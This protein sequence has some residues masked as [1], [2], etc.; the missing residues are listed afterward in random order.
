MKKK[1]TEEQ[2]TILNYKLYQHQQT[3]HLLVLIKCVIVFKMY[4]MYNIKIYIQ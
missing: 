4:E 1:E 3:E 2:R